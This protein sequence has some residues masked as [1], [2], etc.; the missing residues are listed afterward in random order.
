M[1]SLSNRIPAFALSLEAPQYPLPLRM[2]HGVIGM[3]E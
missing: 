1:A 3:A 2:T